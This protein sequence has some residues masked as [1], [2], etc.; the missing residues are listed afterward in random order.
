[1]LEQCENAMPV[2]DSAALRLGGVKSNEC[3]VV[4]REI[5][6]NHLPFCVLHRMLTQ[7]ML[8]SKLYFK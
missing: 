3:T 8:I 1:M 5:F 6:Q 2:L 7:K 4:H